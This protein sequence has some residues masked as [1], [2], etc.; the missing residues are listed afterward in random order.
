MKALFLLLALSLSSQVVLAEPFSY[1]EAF[2]D[3]VRDVT[4]DPD[5]PETEFASAKNDLYQVVMTS[6]TTAVGLILAFSL[7]PEG[8][9]S[10][11]LLRVDH[12]WKDGTRRQ[13]KIGKCQAF[14][15]RWEYRD[16]SLYLGNDLKLDAIYRDGMNL[17]TPTFLD[18]RPPA[19][20]EGIEILINSGDIDT[21]GGF[22]PGNDDFKCG[23]FTLPFWLPI[24]NERPW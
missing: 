1:Y 3:R 21:V 6:E 10:F 17:L 4:H 11:W 14:N 5:F 18:A 12:R 8:R 13:I 9:Y 7:K 19:G 24:P 23:G 2:F 22:G 16:G 15:G 20:S